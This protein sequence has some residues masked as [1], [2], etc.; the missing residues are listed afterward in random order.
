MSIII[1]SAPLSGRIPPALLKSI[2]FFEMSLMSRC[3]VT[4]QMPLAWSWYTGALARI[5][6]NAG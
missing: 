1:G 5:Q 2:G 4:P 3:L 6:A